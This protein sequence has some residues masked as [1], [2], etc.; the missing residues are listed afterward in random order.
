M[1]RSRAPGNIVHY[2]TGRYMRL[3]KRRTLTTFFGIVFTVLLMTCV[4]VGRESAIHYLEDVASLKSGKWHYTLYDVTDQKRQEIEALPYVSGAASTVSLGLTQ[5]PA[6]ANPERPYLNVKA[7]ESQAMDWNNLRLTQGRLPGNSGE[8][9]LSEA[10]RADGSSVQLGDRIDAAFFQRSITGIQDGETTKTYFPFFSLEIAPGE[11]KDLS[12]TFPHFPPNDSF[13]IDQL[14]TGQTAGYTVVGF[15][16]TPSFEPVSA[17]GYTAVTLADPALLAQEEQ[18]NLL[19][20]LDLNRAPSAASL[21]LR[22][23]AGEDKVESNN[24]LLSFSANSSDTTMN[25]MVNLMTGFFLLL[26]LAVSVVLIYNVFNIS[27]R[28]RSRY[29]GMLSSI[30]AT[31]RQK[32]SSVYFEARILLLAALP[33]GILAGFGVVLGGLHLIQPYVVQLVYSNLPQEAPEVHLVLSW[34]ALAW[35]AAASVVTVLLSA[36]LPA[37]KIGKAGP[38]ASIQGSQELRAR[39]GRAKTRIRGSAEGMLAHGFLHR[40]SRNQRSL[41]LAVTAF[42]LVLVVASFGVSRVVNIIHYKTGGS[43]SLETALRQGECVF[44]YNRDAENGPAL[45]EA[46]KQDLQA[47]PEVE[48]MTEW[49]SGMFALDVDNSFYSAEYWNAYLDIAEEFLGQELSREELRERY[50]TDR[51]C[52]VNLMVPDDAALGEI[53]KACGADLD[54]LLHGNGAILVNECTMD[55][56]HNGFE[57]RKPQR[58][59]YF[60]IQHPSSLQPG[61]SFPV[62]VYDAE[63]EEARDSQLTVAGYTN[64]QQLSPYFSVHGSTIWL[65]VSRQTAEDL[66]RLLD[67]PLPDFLSEG[68][69]VQLAAGQEDFVDY[70]RQSMEG[71]EEVMVFSAWNDPDY[72]ATIADSICTILH[73]L[74]AA[75][76]TLSSVVCL[77]NLWNAIHGRMLER[78]RDLAVLRSVGAT[79]RQLEKTLVLECLGILGKGLLLS[80]LLS[81]VLIALIHR[82]LNDIFGHLAF[83]L[84]WGLLAFALLFTTGAV[85][86]ITLYSF[87]QEKPQNLIECIRKDSV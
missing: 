49:Y 48:A 27:F 56:D 86:L 52:T 5:F 66:A 64:N 42:L 40:Q 55:T 63:A 31:A 87:R 4:F 28:E 8:L 24:Y 3:N 85:L 75:F 76:V 53:S 9:V 62:S 50:V 20:R 72:G 80:S 38:I 44:Y 32:R 33:V 15:I 65:L 10:C 77:L 58:Y 46:L 73:I 70:L 2:V 14:W 36:F 79:Q 68:L 47:R 67:A 16:E 18:V 78:R 11:T 45:Y 54:S 30:G 6:S 60:D 12:L 37:R 84:P 71:Q 41:L 29:L 61:E 39:K 82:G 17:A 19:V 21:D 83:R 7:Y 22:D 51:I 69:R 59:R 57:L 74:L 25:L 23:I 35:V 43:P 34:Q 1:K 26:I 81:G 13:R